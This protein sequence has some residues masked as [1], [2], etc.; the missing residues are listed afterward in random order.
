M[1]GLAKARR[2]QV[3]VI[4]EVLNGDGFSERRFDESMIASIMTLKRTAMVFLV[5]CQ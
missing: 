3:E 5:S 2:G 4:A 1:A